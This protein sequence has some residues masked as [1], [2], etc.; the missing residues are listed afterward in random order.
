MTPLEPDPMD[1]DATLETRGN[2]YGPFREQASNAQLLK[3]IIRERMGD[4]KWRRMRA[5][6]REALEMIALKIS[7]IVTGDPNHA[8]SWH[9]IAGYAKLVA[10]R[11]AGVVR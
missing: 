7:R 1:I 5:D 6:Q 3:E 8:D 11:L 9:D 2:S 10:D 4:A